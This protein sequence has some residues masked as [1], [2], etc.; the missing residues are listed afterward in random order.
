MIVYKPLP[1]RWQAF[2]LCPDNGFAQ[3]RYRA[4]EI[5]RRM[6]KILDEWEYTPYDTK[7]AEKGK[8]VHCSAFVC[9]VLDELYRR[10]PT[11]L[12]NIPNDIGFHDRAGAIAGL[13]WFMR[14]YP[15]CYQ[16]TGTDVQPGDVLITG[17]VGGGP[18]HAMIVGPRENTLWQASD[19]GVHYTGMSLPDIYELHATFR[20]RDREKWYARAR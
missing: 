3:D 15:A 20:F 10:E 19:T 18:G 8:G 4:I 13:R 6:A 16:V 9:R 11:P 17:P 7:F 5:E 1:L 14:Q 12:P 2:N